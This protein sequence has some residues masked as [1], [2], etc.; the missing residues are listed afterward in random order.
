MIITIKGIT[1]STITFS[2]GMYVRG[3][4]NDLQ[5][6]PNSIINNVDIVNEKLLNEILNFEKSGFIK[7]VYP[8]P[9]I[10]QKQETAIPSIDKVESVSLPL[11]STETTITT[12][13]IIENKTE[14]VEKIEEQKSDIATEV[15]PTATQENNTPTEN[16]PKPN[17]KSNART[18]KRIQK[19]S[20]D[21]FVENTV[22]ENINKSS[23]VYNVE[24]NE[25]LIKES[26]EANKKIEEDEKSQPSSTENN[27]ELPVQEKMGN[28]AVISTG[29]KKTQQ[30]NMTPSVEKSIHK[31]SDNP[32]LIEPDNDDSKNTIPFIDT[33]GNHDPSDDAFIEL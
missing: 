20:K 5:S 1:N 28:V 33:E 22:S 16:K 6:Y 23:T 10:E 13:E 9:V 2:N 15:L 27:D 18:I 31:I 14:I 19:E 30:V 24:Q 32:F 29:N 11:T 4:S 3:N 26:M 12:E 21:N 7:I 25:S 17:K 8:E